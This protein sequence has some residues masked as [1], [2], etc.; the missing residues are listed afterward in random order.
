VRAPR[1]GVVDH[2]AGNLIS[3]R[4]GL[5]RAGAT[6]T[7][8]TNPDGLEDVDG[9][10]L[11]GVGATATVMDGI[12]S[13]GFE[14]SLRAPE[15]P[16]LGI[17]VGMQVLFE[18]SAEDGARALGLLEGRVEQLT[19]APRLPHIGWNEIVYVPDPLF[20]GLPDRPE[21]YFVHSFAP[22]PTSDQVVIATAT[23]GPSFVAAVR[24]GAVSGTQ[25]HPERSGDIGLTI[26]RNFVTCTVG[27]VA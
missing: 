13:A 11:P 8:A 21:V 9:I 7:I 5:E 16:L 20:D 22:V 1:I 23:H 25:F 19:E 3:I 18:S 14:A 15:V 2:G 17:C 27:A 12:R 6:V 26:L 10:V 4:R 24:R